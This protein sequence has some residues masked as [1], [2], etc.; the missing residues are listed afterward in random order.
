MKK[1]AKLAANVQTVLIDVAAQA[2][3]GTGFCQRAGGKLGGPVFVQAVVLACLSQPEPTLE[4]FAQVAADAGASVTPQ[5]FDQ[6]F[7]KAAAACLRQVLERCGASALAED[8]VA[9]DLLRRFPGGVH[10]Q[11]SSVILLPDALAD[12]FPAY[13]QDGQ[14]AALK[15]QARLDLATGRLAGPFPETVPVSDQD[16]ALPDDDIPAGA[17]RLQDLGYFDLGHFRAWGQRGVY[18]LS[19]LQPRTGVLHEGVRVEAD[20]AG[21][22]ERRHQAVVDVEV[23]LGVRERL[24][25]RLVAWRVPDEVANRRRQRLRKR[26][27]DQGA[28]PNRQQLA[29]CAWAVFLTNVPAPAAADGTAPAAADGAAPAAPPTA[30]AAELGVLARA[31]WQ[32]EVLFK[33]WKSVGRADESRSGKPWRRVCEVYGKLIAAVLRH[34][35]IVAGC[36]RRAGRSWWKAAKAVQAHAAGLAV[37]LRSLGQLAG[38]VQAILRRMQSA[39]KMNK[40]RKNPATFQ[41]LEDPGLAGVGL[42]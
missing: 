26:A 41:L 18:W 21:W 17:L 29:L 6:R 38:V 13:Q 33:L 35:F 14:R 40:R 15:I 5:A 8:P 24:P 34:W 10:G 28:Q 2:V 23:E 7:T 31:R 36:W 16:T 1:V 39:A 30:T 4:D 32:L 12:D 20:L 37:A 19:R 25:A 22:L 27:T 42:A 9:I 11:D 3:Q